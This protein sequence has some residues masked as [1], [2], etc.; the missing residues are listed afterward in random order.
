MA[1]RINHK[2]FIALLTERFPNVAADIDH[3]SEGL[4]HMEMATLAR[5]TQSAIDAQDKETVQQHFRFIDEVFRD[6]APDVENAV[7]V[8]YLE[9]LRFEGRKAGPTK[10]RE[11]LPPRLRQALK[12]LEAYLGQLFEES[13]GT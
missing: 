10:A 11:L 5:A 12:E 2:R 7:H 13:S 8:S 1:T 3:C 6:A 9:N 4:L